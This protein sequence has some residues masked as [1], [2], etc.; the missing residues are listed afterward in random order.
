MLW[1]NLSI[2]KKLALGF[3]GSLIAM[4][5]FSAVVWYSSENIMHLADTAID[6]QK[7]ALTLT[8]REVDHLKWTERLHKLVLDGPNANMSSIQ[9]DGHKCAF[10]QWFYSGDRKRLEQ[11]LP[12]TVQHF[13]ELEKPHL[14]LHESAIRIQEL[15]RAGKLQEAESYFLDVTERS[16]ADVLAHLETTR[17]LV[18]AASRQDAQ[19]Y[20]DVGHSTQWLFVVMQS[21][22]MLMLAVASILF[23]RSISRPL[24]Q[25]VARSREVVNGNLD[26]DLRLPRRDEAG[27]LSQALGSLLD[28]L[29]QKLAENE[30][31]S[32]E[33]LAHAARAEQALRAA[34][35]KEGRI[36]GLLK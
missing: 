3:T 35:E 1:A 11:L 8:L 32:R 18:L 9:S 10:G 31:T 20:L 19:K 22:A 26:V 21:I 12:E 2:N 23:A 15:V 36:S 7:F 13:T 24:G 6:K 17:N 14:A 29:K 5:L 34:E 28:S 4:L 16:S 30:K 33:A 27:Q 25:L